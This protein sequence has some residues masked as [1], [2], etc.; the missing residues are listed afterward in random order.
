MSEDQ[1]LKNKAER[2]KK[3]SSGMRK[4]PYMIVINTVKPKEGVKPNQKGEL[5]VKDI[6]VLETVYFKDDIPKNDLLS[7]DI[8]IDVLNGKIVKN[9]FTESDEQELIEYYMGKFS[10]KII[11]AVRQFFHRNPK[12]WESFIQSA[13][14]IAKQVD[15]E[16]GIQPTEDETQ[17]N[18]LEAE[19]SEEKPLKD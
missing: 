7:A 1:K 3:K 5:D 6:N 12:S 13:Q 19:V 4:L 11:E 18:E 15:E 2:E 10:D 17:V 14:N 9:R 16:K 8:I